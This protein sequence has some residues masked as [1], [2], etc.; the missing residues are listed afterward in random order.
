MRNINNKID[1]P[2]ISSFEEYENLKLKNDIFENVAKEI[3]SHHHLPDDYL[4][5]LEG[6]N[7]VFSYGN[8]RVIKIYPPIHYNHFKSEVLVMRHLKNKLSVNTPEVQYE[9]IISNWPYII[10]SRLDGVLLEGLWEKLDE[11][12]KITIIRELGSLI[13]EVHSLSTD[14]LEAIDCH[15]TQFIFR[16]IDQCM[17]QH[18]ATNLP[19]ELLK[20]IPSYLEAAQQFLPTIKEP[21]LLT[22]E[23]TP[24][25]FLVKQ[26]SGIWHINGLIDFGDSMLGL[27][28]YDLLG[29]G[30]FLIQGNKKLLR[31][32]L[33]AYGYTLEKITP[34][35]SRQLT[36]L[37]LLPRYSNLNV[38]IRIKN[39]K[40]MVSSI[41]D[42]EK[43]VWEL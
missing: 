39:W 16:Q 4:S 38:Q 7:I 8:S 42:I 21:V 33:L 25:N 32:F 36:A 31:E 11:K 43:L 17:A 14:G 23:Y 41:N 15:W 22:G 2:S 27:P 40:N 29:P 10:M 5:L 9:G 26:E 6:T 35:L 13:R 34:L 37:M 19:D 28:E 12:N 1:L 20:Q 30:V 24:M 18:K 3:I